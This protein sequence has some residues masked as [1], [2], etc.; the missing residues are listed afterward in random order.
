MIFYR[1]GYQLHRA[2]HAL[3]IA[4]EKP[5]KPLG[6]TL[7]QVNV[8]LFVDRFPNATMARLARLAV[9]T[10]QA[11]HRTAIRLEQLGL[12]QRDRKIGDDK[13]F[14]LSLTDKGVEVLRQAEAEI[15]AVQNI[16]K[17]HLQP[18]EL[19]MLYELLQRYEAAFQNNKKEKL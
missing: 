4:S 14:Y 9:I 18:Q 19:E 10:P 2:D 1:L 15:K 6:V 8:L 11:L 17:A 16:V 7:T 3:A 13:S 5:L 12:I